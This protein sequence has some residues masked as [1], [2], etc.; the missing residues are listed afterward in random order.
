[1]HIEQALVSRLANPEMERHGPPLEKIGY[2]PRHL[3][4]G[5]LHHVG[6]VDARP[7]ARIEVRADEA[8]QAPP[9]AS[10]QEI[11]RL[12]LPAAQAIEQTAGLGRVRLHIR[13]PGDP[14]QI[15]LPSSQNS[16][17][18]SRHS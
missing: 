12:R 10:Q 11:Q 4:L 2:L 5:F 13:H 1:M 7:Y 3:K 15:K 8:E 17:T 14:F 18:N 16:Q 9:I 6:W